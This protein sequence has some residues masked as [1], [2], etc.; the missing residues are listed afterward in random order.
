MDVTAHTSGLYQTE[1]LSQRRAGILLHISSL[2][3]PAEVGD[4]GSNAY[5]FVDFLESAGITVWQIL[6]VNPTQSDGSPYQSSSVH[7]GNPRFISLEP[8]IER[9]WLKEPPLEEGTLSDDGRS[10]A[11]SLAWDGF[12]EHASEKDRLDYDRFCSEQGHWLEDYALF[13]ALHIEQGRCWWDW[14]PALRDREPQALAMARSRVVDQIATIRFEQYLFYIQWMKLKHYANSKG[15]LLFGDVPIFVAHDSA[16]VWSHPQ[17]F[18]LL[19]NGQPRVV[20][21]VPPDYFSETGQRWGNPLYCWDKMIE[22]GFSFW[23]ER[24]KTQSTLFDFVRIDHF[25]GFEAYWEIQASEETAI[26]GNWVKAPGKELF[27]NLYEVMPDLVLVAEDL[28]VITPEVD[29]LRRSYG[30]PGMKILQFAFSGDA[31][32]PYLPFHHTLDSVVYTGT[33]DN[34]TTLGWYNSLDKATRSYVNEYLGRSI[35]IMPWP[36]IRTAL[37]SR[38]NLAIIPMQDVLA[39]GGEHRMNKPGTTEG[40]WEW[41]FSWDYFEP[42]LAERLKRLIALY[43][44]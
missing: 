17:M 36:L 6:P 12:K 43:G 21:G 38:A 19:E 41:R 8:L 40:N 5:L 42:E 2:P 39:L 23:I 28:G 18:D 35:E 4:L 24:M 26:N 22:D 9:G 15:V 37:A 20:A 30:L 14:L 34:D 7:A 3:G 1:L 16:E 27:A 13:Q 32:N 11:V 10:F 31:D 33:H 44:R 25:R 29:D